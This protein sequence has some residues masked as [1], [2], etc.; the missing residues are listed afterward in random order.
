[1]EIKPKKEKKERGPEY[2]KLKRE[3]FLQRNPTYFKEKIEC[4][5]G[6]SYTR[7]NSHH[8][9]NTWEHKAYENSKNN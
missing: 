6:K 4:E 2:F 9:R 5:C 1:M 8:H 3:E 7:S